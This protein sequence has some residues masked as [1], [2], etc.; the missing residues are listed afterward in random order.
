MY[1]IITFIL[2]VCFLTTSNVCYAK[3]FNVNLPKHN[4]QLSKIKK[5]KHK[6]RISAYTKSRRENG[7]NNLT[8]SGKKPKVGYIAISRDLLK[9]GWEIGKRVYI[10]NMGIFEIQDKMH[11]K[12]KNSIDVYML[13]RKA[14]LEFGVQTLEVTLLDS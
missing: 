1:K 4:K 11:M 12:M 5:R 13:S 10:E 3:N 6:I 7:N 14:A 9:N 2:V 8:A